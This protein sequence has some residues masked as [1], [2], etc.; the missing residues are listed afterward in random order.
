M[1]YKIRM[2]DFEIKP[3]LVERTFMEFEENKKNKDNC[4]WMFN[5][6]EIKIKTSSVLVN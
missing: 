3:E 2:N 5:F 6:I 4:I 1:E